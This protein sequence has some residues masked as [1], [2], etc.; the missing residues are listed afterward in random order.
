[1]TPSNKFTFDFLEIAENV[2][3][4]IFCTHNKQWWIAK[5]NTIQRGNW[6]PCWKQIFFHRWNLQKK[7]TFVYIDFLPFW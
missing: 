7:S 6:L 5:Q 1:M 2:W 3:F 4:L